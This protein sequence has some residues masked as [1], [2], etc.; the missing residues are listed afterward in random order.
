MRRDDALKILGDHAEALRTKYGVQSL[1]IFGSVA[2]DEAR[3]DSD[4]DILV[5]FARPVGLFAFGR[6]QDELSELLGCA[7]DLATPRAL[8]H[9]LRERI[10]REAIRAA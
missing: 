5:E 10:L 7:V 8:H 2:R 9:R 4:I 3:P 1:S 6:L